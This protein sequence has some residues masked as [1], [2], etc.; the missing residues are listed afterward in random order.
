MS[1]KLNCRYHLLLFYKE[2]INSHSKSKSVN[3]LSVEQKEFMIVCTKNL[4][5]TQ[6]LL[7]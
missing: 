5:Y 6:E 4:Y 7:K 1:F 3:E 2:N